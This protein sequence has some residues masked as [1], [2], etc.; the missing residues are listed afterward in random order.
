MVDAQDPLIAQPPNEPIPLSPALSNEERIRTLMSAVLDHVNLN[1]IAWPAMDTRGCLVPPPDEHVLDHL[2]RTNE[3]VDED[4][5]L[6]TLAANTVWVGTELLDC[7]LCDELARYDSTMPTTSG[8]EAGAYLCPNCY[9]E[10]GS[11]SLGA[12]GDTYLMVTAEVSE[13][14]RQRCNDLCDSLGRDHMF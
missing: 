14:V 3:L 1:A 9:Q 6:I 13:G 7:D 10:H 11:G 5:A 2:A 8:G 12:S 4:R